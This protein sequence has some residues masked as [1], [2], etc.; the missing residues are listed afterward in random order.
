MSEYNQH[1]REE[2]IQAAAVIV[3]M[4]QTHDQGKATLKGMPLIFHEI[5]REREKQNAKW[6]EQGHHPFV[7][8]T[9]LGE[10]IGEAC[11]ASLKWKF[12]QDE[13]RIDDA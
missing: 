7:W 4:I 1:Y 10:E 9:I 12:G 2:L 3:A 8:F 5:K 6:G 13:G 11:E